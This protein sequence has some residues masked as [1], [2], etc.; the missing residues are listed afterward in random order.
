MIDFLNEV[1]EIIKKNRYAIILIFVILFILSYVVGIG[2]KF[3]PNFGTYGSASEWFGFWGNVVGGIIST[4]IAAGIA[5]F[6]SKNENEKNNAKQESLRIEEKKD[7]ER[8]RAEEKE[9]RDKLQKIIGEREEKIIKK[10][11]IVKMR[12]AG[13]EKILDCLGSLEKTCEPLNKKLNKFHDHL[14]VYNDMPNF[15]FSDNFNINFDDR[16]T[17]FPKMRTIITKIKNQGMVVFQNENAYFFSLMEEFDKASTILVTNGDS[18]KLKIMSLE[19][20]ASVANGYA[21]KKADLTKIDKEV[22]EFNIVYNE[23][24]VQINKIREYLINYIKEL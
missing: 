2:V 19:K 7:Q 24:N 4:L 6:V 5:Y 14:E 9:E 18:L 3:F 23:N 17:V 16:I 1:W 11:A 13:V 20:N 21:Y 22:E 8:L 10:T 12:V 15:Y